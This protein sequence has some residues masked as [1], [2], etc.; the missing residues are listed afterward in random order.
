[1]ESTVV[2]FCQ[3]NMST[4]CVTNAAIQKLKILEMEQ[5]LYMKEVFLGRMEVLV[6]SITKVSS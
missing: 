5:F 3:R 6:L 2:V 4:A 1:M